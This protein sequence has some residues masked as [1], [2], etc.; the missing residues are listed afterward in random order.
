MRGS[1]AYMYGLAPTNFIMAVNGVP[2][3]DLESFLRETN[4]IKDNTYFRLKMMTFDNV[5]W[6]ATLK[7]NN[8]WFPTVEFVKDS[9]VR[10]GW[11]RVQYVDGVKKEGKGEAAAGQEEVEVGE[12]GMEE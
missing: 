9:A 10:E 2:T 12:D 7:A 8:H 6:V 5:S 4:K 3:L 11:R 1:P